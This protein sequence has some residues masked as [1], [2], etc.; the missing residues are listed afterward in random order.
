[1]LCYIPRQIW[2]IFD[3][4]AIIEIGAVQF[5]INIGEDL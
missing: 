2:W 1:M 3:D 4:P 5:E